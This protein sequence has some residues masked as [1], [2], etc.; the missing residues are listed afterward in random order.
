VAAILASAG[1]CALGYIAGQIEAGAWKKCNEWRRCIIKLQVEEEVGRT[2]LEDLIV[3][4]PI[5]RRV[6]HVYTYVFLIILI[7]FGAT[8]YLIT[9]PMQGGVAA[10]PVQE[11]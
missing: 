2:E 6:A 4:E 8:A 1:F 9:R 3:Y 10:Q 11:R 7:I 5:E